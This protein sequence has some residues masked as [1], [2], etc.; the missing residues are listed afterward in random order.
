[1]LFSLFFVVI[2]FYKKVVI[3]IAAGEKGGHHKKV[4]FSSKLK[5]YAPVFLLFLGN[6]F[7]F[8]SYFFWWKNP[9]FPIF[10]ADLC[11]GHPVQKQCDWPRIP[12]TQEVASYE[13]VQQPFPAYPETTVAPFTNM[14]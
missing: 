1:M 9:F 11:A 8:S 4:I 13:F 14:D 7:L 6:I 5:N 2:F 12:V 10:L 3:V